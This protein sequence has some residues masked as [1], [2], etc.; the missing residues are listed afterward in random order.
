[1]KDILTIE[2][3]VLTACSEDAVDVV[4]PEGVT[5]IGESAFSEKDLLYIF[6]SVV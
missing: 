3:G 4:I 2:D 1:M 6:F 5:E